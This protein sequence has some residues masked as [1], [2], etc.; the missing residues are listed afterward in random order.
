MLFTSFRIWQQLNTPALWILINIWVYRW[1]HECVYMTFS[2]KYFLVCNFLLEMLSS[3]H[4]K[5]LSSMG[6]LSNV[7]IKLKFRWNKFGRRTMCTEQNIFVEKV[8]PIDKTIGQQIDLSRGIQ[9]ASFNFISC[10]DICNEYAVTSNW[11]LLMRKCF[12]FQVWW[13]L[14]F[15]SRTSIIVSKFS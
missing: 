8:T 4:V 1:C 5:L 2:C 15:L 3:I 13:C 9:K 7:S 6:N 11:N 10:K 12:R 14:N